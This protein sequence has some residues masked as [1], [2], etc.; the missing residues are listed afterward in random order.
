MLSAL[1]SENLS[2]KSQAKT[3]K[4]ASKSSK[5]KGSKDNKDSNSREAKDKDSKDSLDRD[6]KDKESR[7][8]NSQ[9]KNE[10]KNAE[11]IINNVMGE[12]KPETTSTHTK[13]NEV[14]HQDRIKDDPVK[15][16]ERDQAT[17]SIKDMECKPSYDDLDD[18]YAGDTPAKADGVTGKTV[19]K[20]SAEDLWSTEIDSKLEENTQEATIICDVDREPS[21]EEEALIIGLVNALDKDQPSEEQSNNEYE[22]VSSLRDK[23]E[24]SKNSQSAQMRAEDAHSCDQNPTILC[25]KSANQNH[26]SAEAM[27]EEGENIAGH[28]WTGWDDQGSKAMDTYLFNIYRDREIECE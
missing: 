8:R 28:N 20:D 10:T 4:S 5:D 19:K 2:T 22:L 15:H 17:K 18:G 14:Q 25:E 11:V 13:D 12:L 1:K 21:Q 3:T 7:G 27:D 6:S 9:N 26:I 23:C 16:D 24:E